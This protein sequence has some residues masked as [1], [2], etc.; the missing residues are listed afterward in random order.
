MYRYQK[1]LLRYGHKVFVLHYFPPL[2]DPI[3]NAMV[4]VVISSGAFEQ[5]SWDRI[6]FDQGTFS[7]INW[8]FISPLIP[9]EAKTEELFC[10]KA[11]QF[12]QQSDL[13]KNESENTRVDLGE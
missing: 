6:E 3:T 4:R 8:R 10:R 12:I 11:P 13:L 7:A 9:V 2:G 5:T 1:N